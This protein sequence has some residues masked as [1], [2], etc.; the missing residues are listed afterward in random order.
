MQCEGLVLHG[1]SSPRCG[2]SW[3]PSFV[4]PTTRDFA[5]S[6]KAYRDLGLGSGIA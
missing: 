4:Q 1:H 5:G 2:T 6:V 3:D